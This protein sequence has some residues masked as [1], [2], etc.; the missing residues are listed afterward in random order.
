MAQ[1]NKKQGEVPPPPAAGRRRSAQSAPFPSFAN[2]GENG[3]EPPFIP[4][5][6]IPDDDANDKSSTPSQPAQPQQ[7]AL[8]DDEFCKKLMSKGWLECQQV[9]PVCLSRLKARADLSTYTETEDGFTLTLKHGNTINWYNIPGPD[10][11]PAQ[12]YIQG[13]KENFD[14]RDAHAIVALASVHGWKSIDVHGTDE[15]KD[16]LWLAAKM[17]GLKVGNYDAAPGSDAYRKWQSLQGQDPTVSA[18]TDNP[19][20]SIDENTPPSGFTRRQSGSSAK[21]GSDSPLFSPEAAPL[22]NTF[23]GKAPVSVFTPAPSSQ[24]PINT[25]WQKSNAPVRRA[26][27]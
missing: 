11:T 6:Q 8:T 3:D 2:D 20:V 27:L 9:D 18:G 15:Q 13:Q 25:Y 21:A 17:Q 5:A 23:N 1:A 24:N 26:A 12:Q 19:T 4:S 16:L 14:L 22:S 7:K 10:G